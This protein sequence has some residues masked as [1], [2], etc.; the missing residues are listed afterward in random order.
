MRVQSDYPHH[1]FDGP[2]PSLFLSEPWTLIETTALKR[3]PL[4]FVGETALIKVSITNSKIPFVRKNIIGAGWDPATGV[5][6]TGNENELQKLY[7]TTQKKLGGIIVG[8]S[9]C[10]LNG[11]K[12]GENSIRIIDISRPRKKIFDSFAKNRKRGIKKAQK[13]GVKVRTETNP[14]TAARIIET[15]KK[16]YPSYRK[17]NLPGVLKIGMKLGV[18]AVFVA[19]ADGE[20]AAESLFLIWNRR[21][22]YATSGT[23]KKYRPYNPADILIWEA[24]LWGKRKGMKEFTLVGGVGK[25]SGINRYKSAFGGKK[26]ERRYFFKR[27]KLGP[28]TLDL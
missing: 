23:L 27:A 24:M 19:Y 13:M 7:A 3:N 15:I 11:V 4:W 2:A 22:L 26:I 16:E 28:F 12:Q 20:P 5:G 10:R 8:M 18:T 14:E 25:D 21:M 9:P 6:M 1:F 17:E